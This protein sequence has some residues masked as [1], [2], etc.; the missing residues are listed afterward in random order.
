MHVPEIL[1]PAGDDESLA[2]ALAAGADAVYFGLDGGMNARA[3]AT[4]FSIER[5]PEL[6]DIIHRAGVRAYVTLNTL[7]FEH[8]LPFA[9][10]VLRACAS[11]G[12]DAIIVQDP[13]VAF[14]ARA[15]APTLEVH[16]STQMTISSP[17]GA[18]FAQQLGATRVVVPRELSVDEIRTFAK[19]TPLQLEVFIHGALCMSWSGQC[20]TSEAWGGRSAN[21]GQCAQSCR[22]PYQ[23]VIDNEVRELG[24]VAYLLS[25]MDLA[26]ARA[27][28]ELSDVGVASLKIEGRLKGP[29]YV[30][31]AVQGY[32]RWRDAIAQKREGTVEAQ[33][34]LQQDLGRMAVAYSRGFSDGF[35]GGAD[36]QSF[37]EGR[38][39]K[40][41]GALLGEVVEV[42]AGE[43]RVRKAQREATGGVGIGKIGQ[44]LGATKVALP[45]IGGASPED[46][47]GVPMEVPE[48]IPGCGVGFDTGRPQDEEPGGPLFGVE[49]AAA[50][51]WLRFGRPGPDLSRV[52]AGDKVWLSSD[53]RL[54]ADA[55]A[56]VDEGLAGAF[57]RIPVKLEVSGAAG[58]PL[59]VVATALG[60]VG[61][62]VS[63]KGHTTVSLSLA[64][65]RVGERANGLGVE[66]LAE[67]LGSFGGT[68]FRLAEVQL[69][70]LAPGLHL[71]VSALK[72]LRR[73]LVAELEPKVLA[74]ARHV[75]SEVPV[76]AKLSADAAKQPARRPW[77]SPAEPRL[78]PLVR[79]AAQLEA[80]IAAGLPE[81]ELDWMELIGLEKAVNR[82]RGAGLSVTIAT[83]RVQ[84]PGEDGIDRRIEKLAPDAVLVRH[85]GGLIHFSLA[86]SGTG[87]VVHGDF[88]LNVTNSVTARHLLSLG[89]D[90]LT[91]A[92]DLDE[93]Q[94]HAMLTSLPAERLTVAV[95]HHIATFHTEHC[96][97]A[98]TI[99]QGRDFRTCGRPCEKHQLSLQDREG[100]RHPVVVDI[101]CR[102]TVFN[103]EAQS[104]GRAVPKL[105]KA[106]VKRFRAEFVWEDQATCASV[107]AAWQDVLQGK[108]S[109]AELNTRLAVHEQFGVTAGTMRTLSP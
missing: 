46:N 33:R 106:G 4:N 12:V 13:A 58:E 72:A 10:T 63:V 39:P 35:L 50:G 47:R 109:P 103:A 62:S 57:G 68:P 7:V 99:S 20:L 53:P 22:L 51:W 44:S 59:T 100:R 37:V 74:A 5:L 66:I 21:R 23:L 77:Q 92:H 2:A 102:N 64:G 104:A 94:L 83:T 38:F 54:T 75:I 14:L 90:T 31:S 28:A 81:V 6:V 70:E 91:A 1:A 71:P 19:G 11:S 49:A 69:D 84:K 78:I 61:R 80:V 18:A 88:S 45:V 56:A 87:P 67:K 3:R 65:E 34:Q 30:L 27:V 29:A 17:E 93:T 41:R 108:C 42:R 24:D 85:W 26:G 52:R 25:P 79:T 95:H 43:V 76:A 105:L 8:E 107:L 97:Y 96:V 16:T 82:A 36:H 55:K 86:N 32:Q 101:G 40:N 48:P 73:S 15:V 98:H 9:E 89:C 60:H